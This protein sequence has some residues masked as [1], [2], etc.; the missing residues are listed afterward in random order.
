MAYWHGP[1]PF[2]LPEFLPPLNL[3]PR[4][5]KPL[6]A[7]AHGAT[8]FVGHEL[9]L[10]ADV[11]VAAR[12]TQFSQ[13]EVTRGLFPAGGGTVRFTREAGWGNAMRYILTGDAWNADEAYRMG[14]VQAVTAP[15]KEFDRAV[16]L[17]RKIAAAA[18]LG[19]RAS[20]ASANQALASN[21]ATAYAALS[22][23]LGR[24]FQTEDAREATRAGEERRAPVF[25]GR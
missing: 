1:S 13:A 24:L 15:G 3:P 20:L 12:D 17:A 2:S 6:V 14:L 25:Q 23:T 5:V 19:V 16:E 9:F 18:P 11:R 21:E 7:A 10:A 22:A 4:R 8:A